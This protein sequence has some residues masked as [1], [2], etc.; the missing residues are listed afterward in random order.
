[1][2]AGGWDNTSGNDAACSTLEISQIGE[3]RSL[4]FHLIKPRMKIVHFSDSE[5]SVQTQSQKN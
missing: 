4:L 1:M 3:T 2:G 5:G